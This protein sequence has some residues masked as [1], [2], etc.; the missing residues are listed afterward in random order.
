MDGLA[1]NR[2]DSRGV[3]LRPIHFEDW[4]SVSVPRAAPKVHQHTRCLPSAVRSHSH[5]RD[6]AGWGEREKAMPVHA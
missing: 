6:D 3:Q 4:K 5:Q 2:G 1:P